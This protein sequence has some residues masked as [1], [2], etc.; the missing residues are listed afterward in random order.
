MFR[1]FL[2]CALT[3][4]AHCHPH[5]KRRLRLLTSPI[6]TD[7]PSVLPL[8]A[9]QSTTNHQALPGALGVALALSRALHLRLHKLKLKRDFSRPLGTS[10]PTT[11]FLSFN[12]C[13]TS[14]RLHALLCLLPKRLSSLQH[15]TSQAPDKTLRNPSPV[16]QSYLHAFAKLLQPACST[17]A[18]LLQLWSASVSSSL[19]D[20]LHPPAALHQSICFV[21]GEV[22]PNLDQPHSF[23]TFPST[24]FGH[25]EFEALDHSRLHPAAPERFILLV[26]A[27]IQHQIAFVSILASSQVAGKLRLASPD[28]GLL[29]CDE[30]HHSLHQK[31]HNGDL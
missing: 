26:I 8:K 30:L 31:V 16:I 14:G 9:P 12:H 28:S 29:I 25:Y 13:R 10:F 15:S 21:I 5:L 6:C 27:V 18:L 1:V 24:P 23:C 4:C 20:A 19:A 17:L 11:Y 22:S 7:T 3:H 2:L